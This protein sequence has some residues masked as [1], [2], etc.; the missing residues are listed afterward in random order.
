[1]K[2]NMLKEGKRFIKQNY[3]KMNVLDMLETCKYIHNK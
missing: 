1:M 3:D 2:K